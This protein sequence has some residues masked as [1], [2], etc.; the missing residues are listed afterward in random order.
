[1]LL[2]MKRKG[3]DL[4]VPYRLLGQDTQRLLWEGDKSFDGINDFFE[5]LEGKRQAPCPCAPQPLPDAVRVP[6]LPWQP[7]SPMRA[8]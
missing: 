4:T 1:M 7:G 6:S 5:Y 3:V 2:A 8:L